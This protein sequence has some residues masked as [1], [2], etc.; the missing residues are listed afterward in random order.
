VLGQ[1]V[2]ELLMRARRAGFRGMYVPAMQVHHHV[3]ARRLTRAY[4][5]RW[6]FG[7]GVSRAAL[8]RMQPVTELG[9]DLRL[10][11]HVLGVPRFMYGSAVRDVLGLIRERVR[12]RP[13]Q[14]FRHQMMLAYFLGYFWTRWRERRAGRRPRSNRAPV[15]SERRTP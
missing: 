9:I 6:W 15:L 14:S 1:E 5:R 3:P 8:E 13:E 7:K 11:P 10:T 12:A 4:F 2:P